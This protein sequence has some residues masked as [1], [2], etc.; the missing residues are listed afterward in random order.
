MH[1]ANNM[2][3]VGRGGSGICVCDVCVGCELMRVN[4]TEYFVRHEKME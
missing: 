2:I 3:C 4:V 1:A